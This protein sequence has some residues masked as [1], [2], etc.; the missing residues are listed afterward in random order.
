MAQNPPSSLPTFIHGKTGME[1]IAVITDAHRSYSNLI[2]GNW[3]AYPGELSRYDRAFVRS[4][5]PRRDSFL[6]IRTGNGQQHPHAQPTSSSMFAPSLAAIAAWRTRL[7][8]H[9][10]KRHLLAEMAF[11]VKTLAM[12]YS[13]MA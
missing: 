9:K 4:Q 6:S 5:R 11:W 1:E 8:P 12:T 13:C 3:R 10:G 2:A 7:K